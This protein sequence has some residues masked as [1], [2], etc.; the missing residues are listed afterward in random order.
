MDD[1]NLTAI[2]NFRR[3][4]D[5][6]ATGG[7]P[8]EAQLRDIADA[9]FGCVINLALTTSTDAL[10]DEPASVRALGLDHLHIPVDFETPTA[11][12]YERF[13]A[14]MRERSNATSMQRLAAA[15]IENI[16]TI[17]EY[18]LCSSSDIAIF[19]S[20]ATCAV[21]GTACFAQLLQP[22]A[23]SSSWY[24]STGQW[25]CSDDAGGQ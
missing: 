21:P 8:T 5:R 1:K 25:H 24:V 11:E 13:A 20:H 7:Q 3:I 14:A 9:G 18:R 4:D 2:R 22:L 19:V 23:P 15:T 17:A 16:T 10:A 6:I 12:D